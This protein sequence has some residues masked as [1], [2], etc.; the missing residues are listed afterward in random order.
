MRASEVWDAL[1]K[2]EVDLGEG[3]VGHAEE[4]AVVLGAKEAKESTSAAAGEVDPVLVLLAKRRR[5][6][7][8]E[9]R[10]EE[11]QVRLLDAH[12]GDDVVAVRG[13]RELPARRARRCAHARGR[14]RRCAEAKKWRALRGV[15]R[16]GTRGGSRGRATTLDPSGR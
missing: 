12:G 5:V 1:L 10:G 4:Y 2:N 15:S 13:E 14:A 3:G 9:D 7:E 16:R 6:E 11:V 8:G